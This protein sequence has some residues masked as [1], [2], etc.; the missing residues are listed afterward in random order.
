MRLLVAGGGTGGHL[1]PGVAV[2]EELL[3]RGGH[4]VRFAGSKDGIEARLLPTLGLPFTPVRCG[5][6]VGKGIGGKVGGLASTLAG[7]CDALGLIQ[8]FKPDACLGVGGYASFPVAAAARMKGVFT[9]IQEQNATPGLAN[10]A[11]SKMAEKIYAGDEAAASVFPPEKTVVT[12]TPIRN[13]FAAPFPYDPPKPGT[14]TRVLVLGGSQGAAA[15][16]R[17]VPGALAKV[18]TPLEIRHQAGRGKAEGVVAAYA[19]REGVTVEEFIMDMAGAYS[20]AQVVIARAGALTIAELEG[21]GRPAILVPFP[22]AAANHQEANARAFM[23]RG[24]G[25][26]VIERELTVEGLAALV[27]SW[28]ADPALS[29]GLAAKAAS[30]ARRDAARTIVDDLIA[31]SSGRGH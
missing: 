10:R 3:A 21:A 2:A 20:W 27:T 4:E 5:A 24:C 18:E 17:I 6:L 15:L 22:Y 23:A 31:S 8:S 26:C 29:S 16:N 13:G 7:I 12:G 28:I 1:Y 30:S 9:A 25:V 11:L 14:P 19:G